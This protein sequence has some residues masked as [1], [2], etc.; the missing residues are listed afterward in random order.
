MSP[1]RLRLVIRR[2]QEKPVE[3]SFVDKCFARPEKC[4]D[5]V[6]MNVYSKLYDVLPPSR[7]KKI[8]KVRTIYDRYRV[9]FYSLLPGSI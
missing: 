9:P 1:F 4:L 3:N 8:V 2:G 7:L 6:L 5:K